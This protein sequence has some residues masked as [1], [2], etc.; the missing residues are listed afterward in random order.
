MEVTV[1]LTRE[2]VGHGDYAPANDPVVEGRLWCPATLPSGARG[3]WFFV[4]EGSPLI[5]S[6]A[7]CS[8]LGHVVYQCPLHRS[9]I[10]RTDPS[11]GAANCRTE[12]FRQEPLHHCG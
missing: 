5:C 2:P 12:R 3:H 7:T 8:F 4:D 9:F 1:E 10:G 11:C 6:D